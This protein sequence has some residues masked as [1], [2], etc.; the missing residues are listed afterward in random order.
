MLMPMEWNGSETD[1][2]NEMTE[3]YTLSHTQAHTTQFHER[4]NQSEWTRTE[5]NFQ[6]IDV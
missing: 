4:G 3:K 1:N 5:H 6:I 2:E